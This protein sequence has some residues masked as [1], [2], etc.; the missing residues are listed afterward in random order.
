MIAFDIISGEYLTGS[1][2]LEYIDRQR[3]ALS[4]KELPLLALGIIAAA[5]AFASQQSTSQ[6]FIEDSHLDLF[7][8]NAYIK[9]DYRDGLPDKAEWGQGIIATFESG[10]TQGPVGFGVDGIAQYAVRLDGGRGRS[11]AGGIDFFARMMMAARS[12]I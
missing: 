2:S 6:G 8:R 10:F 1:D 5:P 4:E 7:L 3:S 12:P 11:G 9:R